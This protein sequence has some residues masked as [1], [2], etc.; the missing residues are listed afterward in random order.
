MMKPKIKPTV[1]NE[2]KGRVFLEPEYPED[3]IP[4]PIDAKG[5]LLIIFCIVFW[6]LFLTFLLT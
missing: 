2:Y 6:V 3:D 1:L 5:F 4:T